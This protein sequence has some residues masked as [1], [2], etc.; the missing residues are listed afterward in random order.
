MTAPSRVRQSLPRPTDRIT[1]GQTGLR[2]S[3][4]CLGMTVSPETVIAAFEEGV[5]FFF[6]TAD[7]HWP[8]YDGVRKGLAKLLAGSPSRRDQI[9]VGVVSYLDNPLF[10]ALQFH[11]VTNEITGL[12]RVDLLIAGAVSSDHSFYSRVEAMSRARAAGQHGARAIG[13]T[14]HQRPLALVA[15]HY[16]MLDISFIRYNSAHPGASRD[17]F[18]YLSGRNIPIF[19]FK[20]TMSQ[21]T[22]EMFDTL[23]LGPTYWRPEV[24][25]YYRFV[26]TRPEIDGILC[27]PMQPAEMRQLA[28]ALAK[29]P[30]TPDQEAYMI[31]LSSLVHAQVLT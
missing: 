27:S 29:G 8:L 13:A 10:G 5:N 3:P 11:E 30:L 26:L 16:G 25:D 31:W 4:V 17:L 2:V 15:Q 19:N 9:V 7:L 22:P 18:P 1:L 21:V 6:I 20:S 24:C 28:Q 23:N 14:F 12:E